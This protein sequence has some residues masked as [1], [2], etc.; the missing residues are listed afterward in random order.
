MAT[1][2]LQCICTTPVLY[3][4]T[5]YALYEHLFTLT[6]SKGRFPKM[7]KIAGVVPIPKSSSKYN[8][9]NYRP[10]SLF[11]VVSKHLERIVHSLLWEHLL[12]CAP[13]SDKQ[14]GFQKGKST[15]TALLYAT[16]DWFTPLDQQKDGM[17]IFFNFKKAFDTVPHR[18]LLDKLCE[19]GIH[20]LLLLWLCSYLSE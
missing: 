3:M 15:T 11:S 8:P 6:L 10:T 9:S 5:G 17:C 12:T 2:I 14:W 19:I 18:K 20:P 1:P 13:I 16:H 4:R 7:W